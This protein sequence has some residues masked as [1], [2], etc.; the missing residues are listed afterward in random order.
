M[1]AHQS[2]VASWSMLNSCQDEGRE[3]KLAESQWP[4]QTNHQR[5]LDL[6]HSVGSENGMIHQLHFIELITF[7]NDAKVNKS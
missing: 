7:Y 3:E 4:I 6:R 1:S 2:Q 5:G